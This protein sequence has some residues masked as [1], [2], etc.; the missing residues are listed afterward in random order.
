MGVT[1]TV[2]E[3]GVHVS[4][5]AG[6]QGTS[7]TPEVG[8]RITFHSRSCCS[9]ASVLTMIIIK[10]SSGDF[11]FRPWLPLPLEELPRQE[12]IAKGQ[13]R[14]SME[15][16][17]GGELLQESIQ[18]RSNLRT[19]ILPPQEGCFQ[20][21]A[22]CM[23]RMHDTTIRAP[24]MEPV[25]I[26]LIKDPEHKD[27]RLL[28]RPPEYQIVNG[29]SFI[30]NHHNQD[31]DE[32]FQQI[33]PTIT[34]LSRMIYGEATGVDAGVPSF[35]IQVP[36]TCTSDLTRHTSE[37]MTILIEVPNYSVKFNL[38]MKQCTG[39]IHAGMEFIE[40]IVRTD[41]TLPLS[42][43]NQWASWERIIK[44]IPVVIDEIEAGNSIIPRVPQQEPLDRSLLCGMEAMKISPRSNE[45]ARKAFK[46]KAHLMKIKLRQ[47]RR[48]SRNKEGGEDME[49]ENNA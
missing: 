31:K 21:F 10:T 32:A 30:V 18:R 2:E 40:C 38:Q 11:P 46:A 48:N 26:N 5:P 8:Q 16:I 41:S 1:V 35:F 28:F 19:R 33:Y 15:L 42:E 22:D 36:R 12:Q 43:S 37:R 29:R 49:V 7:L 14:P 20:S 23:D 9:A 45:T 34:L 17:W 27:G 13:E 6:S 39:G 4:K 24:Q 25:P 47:R 3:W 44:E